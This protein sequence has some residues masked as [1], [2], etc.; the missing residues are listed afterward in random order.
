MAKRVRAE[1]N[2]ATLAVRGIAMAALLA[3]GAVAAVVAGGDVVDSRA[4][5]SATLPSSAGTI[6]DD[7]PVQYRGV[8]VGRLAGVESGTDGARL[9]LRM[10]PDLLRRVP[11]NVTVR[12]LPRTVF[13]D[14][15][16][17]LAVP[18]GARPEGSL[19]DG[20]HLAPDESR[21]T[22]ALYD[23]YSRLYDLIDD[24]KPAQLKVALT[25]VADTLRGRGARIGELIDQAAETARDASPLVDDLGED[26]T[27]A[28]G[29][30]RDL[31]AASPELLRSL[32]DAVA[33]S[34]TV[35][36]ERESLSA[37]L[38]AGID[39]SSRSERF[40]AD[41]ASRFIQLTHATGPLSEALSRHPGALS[42]TMDAA[43][44]FLDGANRTF[45][46][47]VFN[48]EAGLTLDQPYPY[49]AADCPRYPGMEGPNCGAARRP[50]PPLPLPGGTAGPVGSE[51]ERSQL[52]EL[53]P[54]L[55]GTGPRQSRQ[56][57]SGDLLSLLLGPMV[58]GNRVVVR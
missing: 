45:A 1:P 15:Y 11:A 54:L 48:I 34:R 55:P 25:T 58:R 27:T 20:A 18:E 12:L 43:N 2:R 17:D 49:T 44:L 46:T 19:A 9:K 36:A 39:L 5:V 7:S 30:A 56:D 40:L 35:V 23:A 6:R 53:A 10:E 51:L 52:R 38:S 57:D 33:L 14:Q 41:N 26:L 29:I 28:A 16:L 3:T 13:G 31:S 8:V 24:L 50:R 47:G 4:V 37:V 22:V 42:D 32:D 21:R